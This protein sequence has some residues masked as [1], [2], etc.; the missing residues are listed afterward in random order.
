MNRISRGGNRGNGGRRPALL[1]FLRVSPLFSLPIHGRPMKTLRIVPILLLVLLAAFAQDRPVSLYLAGDSTIAQKLVTRRPET[2]WGEM[3]QQHFDIDR[4]RVQ[5]HAR[6][7]RSTRTFIE[8]GRWQ[9]IVDEL[10]PGDWVLIQFGHNDA[11]VE[12]V[13][14]YT[15]PADYRRNL[16]R[17]VA[18]VRAKGA[19]PVL[20]TPVMRRRFDGEGVFRD[21]HGEYPDLVRAA[22]AELGVP[23][24]DMHRSSE[25]VLVEYGAERSKSLFLHLAPGENA[26]YPDGLED[27]THFSPAGAEV[28][29]RLAVDGIRQ[30]VPDLAA[31][32]VQPSA[33]TTP[34]AP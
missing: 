9:A 32:L 23:L 8:E 14:R 24:V 12:K 25:R 4:V 17:F 15:P 13:D 2:G 5:N 6:N 22:A 16:A 28:M 33:A 18:D 20:M 10:R 1:C 30:S 21:A 7:G 3:L 11:S 26:N 34:A 19:R 29:A 27:N 31:L